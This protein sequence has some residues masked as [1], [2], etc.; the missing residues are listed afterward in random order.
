MHKNKIAVLLAAT[1][2]LSIAMPAIAAQIKFKLEKGTAGSYYK[3]TETLRIFVPANA[4]LATLQNLRLELDNVDV[5]QSMKRLGSHATYTPVQ[6][7]AFGFHELR[8][9]EYAPDGSII[10]HARWKIQVRK[11]AAFQQSSV[12][13]NIELSVA[14]RFADK[15]LTVPKPSKN[16]VNGAISFNAEASNPGWKTTAKANFIQQSPNTESR[17]FNVADF[18]F[19]GETK[20]TVVYAGHHGIEATNLA[21][22][23]FAT[24]GVSVKSFSSDKRFQARAFVMRTNAITGFKYG[25]GVSDAKNRV[26][27]FSLGAYPLIK[28]PERLFMGLTYVNGRGTT[29]GDGDAGDDL[30]SGG[31]ARSYVL[32]SQL[33]KRLRIR[34]EYAR[35]V[36]DFDGLNT[37][38]GAEKDSAWSVFAVYT[39]KSTTFKNKPLTWNVT[40]GVQRVG[41]FYKSLANPGLPTDKY[42]STISTSMSWS[43]FNLTARVARENDNVE[44]DVKRPRVVS[45]LFNLTLG[46]QPKQPKKAPTGYSRFFKQANYSFNL[47]RTRSREDYRPVG[48]TADVMDKKI[49]VAGVNA[50]FTPGKWSW[51][52][53]YSITSTEDY[54][55]VIPDTREHTTSFEMNFPV[56]DRLTLAPTLQY[57]RINNISQGIFSKALQTGIGVTYNVPN[58]WVVALSYALNTNI[59]T[60]KSVDTRG[61]IVTANVER[62]LKKNSTTKPGWSFFMNASYNNTK[63]RVSVSND[64]NIYQIYIGIKT[65]MPIRY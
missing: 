6:P 38:F 24:R 39:P 45:N 54:A 35:S 14:R 7:L 21:V 50:S 27:G 31:N 47:A 25:L 13:A 56:N 18:L 63:D 22:N 57:N 65:N 33:N 43:T 3:P 48:S 16:T 34:G 30:R 29:T 19:T 64:T 8:L 44:E 62:I 36:F 17:R 58:K 41:T 61:H 10:E 49:I 26:R 55:N 46:Y 37:G 5:T 52:V 9:V 20:N 51:A 15:G 23:N 59:V 11:S 60:D 40:T 1:L 2:G 4:P 42:A 53:G 12:E 28:R 32:D